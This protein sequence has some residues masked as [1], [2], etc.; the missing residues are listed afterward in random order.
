LLFAQSSALRARDPP[1]VGTHG[2]R[3]PHTS[4]DVPSF[5][6]VLSTEHTIVAPLHAPSHCSSR[7][8]P[9]PW[10]LCSTLLLF[11]CLGRGRPTKANKNPDC[12]AA[13]RE[14]RSGN[15]AF[16]FSAGLAPRCCPFPA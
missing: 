13:H 7:V 12:L 1:L 15:D 8:A 11:R 5:W 2:G 16:Q 4:A 9:R 3:L 6:H 10:R 14:R